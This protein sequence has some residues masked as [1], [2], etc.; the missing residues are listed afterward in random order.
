MHASP[1]LAAAP[2]SAP[3]QAKTAAVEAYEAL[4]AGPLAAYLALSKDVGGVVAEQANHVEAAF[5]AQSSFVALVAACKPVAAA[6][7]PDFLAPTQQPLVAATTVR[8]PGRERKFSSHLSA[9]SEGIPALGW[10]ALPSG[11]PM[12]PFVKDMREAAEFW[13]NR[14]IK[15]Y[16]DS[17]VAALGPRR[18]RQ[19]Q[20]A[21]R[22]GAQLVCTARGPTQVCLRASRDRSRLECQGALR[23]CLAPH[24]ISVRRTFSLDRLSTRAYSA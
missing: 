11:S 6:S 18:P 3:A 24:A 16:K 5:R 4:L 20:E 22:V 1:A 9:V 12:A 19:R 21:G 14:V 17:S 13:V 2:T 23:S 7:R 8:E 10:V 15:E